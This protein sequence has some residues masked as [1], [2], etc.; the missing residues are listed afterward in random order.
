MS[1]ALRAHAA[2]ANPTKDQQHAR[3]A[4]FQRI[5]QYL[6]IGIDMSPLFSDVIMNAH[7]KDMATKKMLYHYLTHYAQAK[8]DLALLTVNTL[9][10]D[11]RDED[12][13]VR[14][15]AVR[16]MAS[17]RVPDLVEYLVRSRLALAR[18]TKRRTGPAPHL[19]PRAATPPP[20]LGGKSDIARRARTGPKAVRRAPFFLLAKPVN[21]KTSLTFPSPI[22]LSQIGAVQQGLQDAHPYPRKTAAMGVLKIYDL[23]PEAVRET[24]LL[25]TLRRMLLEDQNAATVFNCVVTLMEIDGPKSLATKQIVYGLINRLKDFTEWAQVTILEIVAL[26]PPADKTETFDVMNALEDRL[27]HSNSAVVLATV[28][29]FLRA[30]LELPDVHQQV[31][32]RMKA[33]LLTLAQTESQEPA[34]AVWAHLHLLTL[35][36]PPLFANDFKSFFCRIGDPPAVKRLKIEALV[37]VADVGNTYEI[38]T[39]LSEYVSDV[40]PRIAREAV[41]GIARVALEGDGDSAGPIVDRLLQFVHHG[42]GYVVAETLAAVVSLTRKHGEVFANACVAAISNIEMDDIDEPGGRVALAYLLGEFGEVVPE[43]PYV[44]EPALASFEE[45]PDARVRLELLTAAAKLFFKR[46]PEMRAMLQTALQAGCLDADQDVHDRAAMYVRLL[47]RDPDAAARVVGG[48]EQK[49][50]VHNFSDARERDKYA[51]QIF[52]EFNTLSVLYRE[53]AFVFCDESAAGGRVV[54]R[55]PSAL[56]LRGGDGDGGGGAGMPGDSLI[57]FGGDDAVSGGG[58]GGALGGDDANLLDL[59]DVP[60]M[61]TSGATSVHDELG[62]LEGLGGVSGVDAARA[63]AGSAPAVLTLAPAPT[64]D[65]GTFQEKWSVLGVTPGCASSVT[66]SMSL[67]VGPGVASL[68]AAQPLVTHLAAHAF[69]TVASGG[70]PPAIKIFAHAADAGSGCVFL[71][72]VVVDTASGTASVTVKSDADAARAGQLEAVVAAALRGFGT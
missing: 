56:D 34:Y 26:Y 44:L 14:G 48:L 20:P 64:M 32:E 12:P 47:A 3:R 42:A 39:E 8:A 46:P 40:E 16:S 10:K 7:T 72:E 71:L 18:A 27:Q 53:P 36:A 70:A 29:C 59:Y 65:P 9:Q 57:D 52:D 67:G 31:F 17:M 66:G 13:V 6:T 35:R 45:E 33:P 1:A 50:K 69:V 23:H 41:R 21:P 25:Q 30:T 22:A 37:A 49:N 55:A 15:L 60:S 62:R 38:V 28:K 63:S 58:A 54:P 5:I 24:E 19:S 43:A 61:A 2:K 4:L 68:T 51:P 11:C